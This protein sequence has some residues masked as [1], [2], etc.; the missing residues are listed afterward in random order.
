M[1][2]NLSQDYLWPPLGLVNVWALKQGLETGG[3][4]VVLVCMQLLG[5][6]QCNGSGCG[7][8]FINGK[9]WW[10]VKSDSGACGAA[11]ASLG[12]QVANIAGSEKL[13]RRHRLFHNDVRT[14]A[15]DTAGPS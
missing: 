15:G 6:T 10:A 7:S 12:Q 1:K 4:G 9:G 14:S 13:A 11:V 3:L 2:A 8:C 5:N